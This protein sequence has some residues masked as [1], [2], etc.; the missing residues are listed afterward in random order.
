MTGT[1]RSSDGLDARRRRALI[2]AWRRGIREMDLV[3]GRYA[4]AY[5]ETL[6]DRDL[7]EFEA[8]ME[9]PDQ[10][11]FAWFTGTEPVATA[12]ATPLFDAIVAFHAR[13]HD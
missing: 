11:L 6:S 8:L 10:Q 12:N 2:R 9:V 4:D 5:I 7:A 13:R 3:L 1:S